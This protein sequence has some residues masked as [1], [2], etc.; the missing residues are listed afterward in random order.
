M[1]TKTT[2][3]VY[4]DDT[5]QIIT[6]KYKLAPSYMQ[7]RLVMQTNIPIN[8]SGNIEQVRPAPDR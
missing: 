1:Q 5:G 7:R 2:P 8:L 3:T 6:R 4:A